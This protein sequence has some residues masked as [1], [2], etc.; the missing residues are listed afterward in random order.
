MS[1][2]KFTPEQRAFIDDLRS[3]DYKQTTGQLYVAIKGKDDAFCVMG[4]AIEGLRQRGVIE[5]K[6]R[7]DSSDQVGGYSATGKSGTFR[8]NLPPKEVWELLGFK[9]E[10]GHVLEPEDRGISY[11]KSPEKYEE[12]RREMHQLPHAFGDG[13]V[14]A[15]DGGATFEAV[16]DVLEEFP[17]LFFTHGA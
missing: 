11:T 5:I 14:S 17:H 4:V 10:Y 16:A 6:R 2:W 1:D 12:A 8:N 9:D 7:V 13:L 15:N 3:G